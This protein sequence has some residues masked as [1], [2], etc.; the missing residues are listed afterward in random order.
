MSGTFYYGVNR[1]RHTRFGTIRCNLLPPH[2]IPSSTSARRLPGPLR[3]PLRLP[4]TF[5]SSSGAA[6]SA[7]RLPAG[8]TCTSSTASEFRV[9]LVA[10]PFFAAPS[11]LRRR[12]TRC[13]P[14]SPSSPDL[15]LQG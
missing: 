14:S 9:P 12:S 8:R 3:V 10:T 1:K 15:S 5:S 4:L 2:T 13:R 7:A 6:A 11:R